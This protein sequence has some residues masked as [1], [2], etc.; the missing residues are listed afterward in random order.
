MHY[1]LQNT[2][3][4]SRIPVPK[5]LLSN[6]KHS[7][8]SRPQACE[9]T[10]SPKTEKKV[11]D[12][13]TQQHSSSI[14]QS[15]CQ[16]KH[17]TKLSGQATVFEEPSSSSNCGMQT[18]DSGSLHKHS[19]QTRKRVSTIGLQSRIP[20]LN[21]PLSDP[22]H[23]RSSSPSKLHACAY[24][25]SPN[26]EKKIYDFTTQ[27]RS[28]AIP[29]SHFQLKHRTMLSRQ[30]TVVEDRSST[31]K[32]RMHTCSLPSSSSLHKDSS[33]TP[34]RANMLA[35]MRSN[36][37][38]QGRNNPLTICGSTI[39]NRPI[40]DIVEK[41]QELSS[42]A[43]LNWCSLARSLFLT[44]EEI[45]QISKCFGEEEG[46]YQM[47]CYWNIRFYERANYS[48][49]ARALVNSNQEDIIANYPHI[50]RDNV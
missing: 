25:P 4:P 30:T 35:A 39:S 38:L 23:S 18:H 7:A 27:Q 12:F 32:W 3:S 9:Y 49:L 50:F 36:D 48:T 2:G 29:H 46:C 26:T 15:R 41:F 34:K 43:E 1:C 11:Y 37:S 24:T 16:L 10:P 33:Q 44:L 21:H 40:S 17:R 14:P 5:R 28:S 45:D 22:Q 6:P 47:L 8:L 19:P 42:C 13:T 20:L 31:P